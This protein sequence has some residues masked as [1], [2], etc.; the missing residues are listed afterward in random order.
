MFRD[1]GSRSEPNDPLT[2]AQ[3]YRYL[4]RLLRLGLEKQIEFNDP[5]YPQFY[6]LS[7]ETAKIGNDNPDNF[8][9]NCAV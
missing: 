1:K 9:Q 6:S 5:Q 3:G 4:M 8:Y 2:Q 7:H